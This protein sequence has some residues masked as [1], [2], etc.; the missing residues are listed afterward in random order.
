MGLEQQQPASSLA[1]L[2][3]GAHVSGA[4]RADWN[5][6]SVLLIWSRADTCS[7][8]S[9][10]SLTCSRLLM[11]PVVIGKSWI[12]A[13]GRDGPMRWDCSWWEQWRRIAAMSITYRCIFTAAQVQRFIMWP[14]W[15]VKW[16]TRSSQGIVG[17]YGP[18]R[19][20]VIP[21]RGRA[22]TEGKTT[23]KG[24]KADK[25]LVCILLL[26]RETVSVLLLE[27]RSASKQWEKHD[28]TKK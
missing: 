17:L 19:A 1:S 6:W 22:R 14:L 13:L 18:F 16:C 15:W 12:D 26:V 8:I 4:D 20:S 21:P 28:G 24:A 10:I 2:I 23:A 9:S 27:E 11:S 5:W 3:N 7:S 25:L